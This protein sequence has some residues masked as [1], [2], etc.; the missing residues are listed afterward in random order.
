MCMNFTL[1]KKDKIALAALSPLWVPLAL[2]GGLLYGVV[3]AGATAVRKVSSASTQGKSEKERKEATK[4]AS[5][6]S[7]G[8][9]QVAFKAER[10]KLAEVAPDAHEQRALL[11]FWIGEFDLAIHHWY[12][13]HQ[14][15]PHVMHRTRGYLAMALFSVGRAEEGFEQFE[16]FIGSCIVE[17]DNVLNGEALYQSFVLAPDLFQLAYQMRNDFVDPSLEVLILLFAGFLYRGATSLSERRAGLSLRMLYRMTFLLSGRAGVAGKCALASYA[18]VALGGPRS[19]DAV[20]ADPERIESLNNCLS[21]I[22]TFDVMPRGD[23]DEESATM[24]ELR[25]RALML[26]GKEAVDPK[27]NLFENTE[28]APHYKLLR[29]GGHALEKHSFKKPTWC[30][31]CGE[32]ITGLTCQGSRCSICRANVHTAC[33]QAAVKDQC[34]VQRSVTDAQHRKNGNFEKR[35]ELLLVWKK[36]F[37]GAPRDLIQLI[38]GHTK[39]SFN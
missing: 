35:R 13:L 15:R 34:V 30:N 27:I 39:Q 11:H 37:P 12:L 26:L 2:V 25:R 7:L 24:K 10:A 17:P 29:A 9:P 38:D 5:Q 3:I 32:F 18:M 4:L 23:R 22:D 16:Q 31:H 14:T 19:V 6:G 36:A 20:R 28:P 33:E 21:Q 1:T 8:A